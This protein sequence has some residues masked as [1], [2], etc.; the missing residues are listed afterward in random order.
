MPED[1]NEF[2]AELQTALET[3]RR[4]VMNEIPDRVDVVTLGQASPDA[5]LRVEQP[6]GLDRAEAPAISTRPTRLPREF[7]PPIEAPELPPPAIAR[8]EALLARQQETPPTLP[9]TPETPISGPPLRPQPTGPEF[10]L[11]TDVSVPGIGRILEGQGENGDDNARIGPKPEDDPYVQ[12]P[13][14]EA[15]TE[16]A[17]RTWILED[18]RVTEIVPGETKI[19][20]LKCGGELH[21][22]ARYPFACD[23]VIRTTWARSAL[24]PADYSCDNDAQRASDADIP[25]AVSWN[26]AVRDEVGG[27]IEA[28]TPLTDQ[29]AA[30]AAAWLAACECVE[31]EVSRVNGTIQDSDGEDIPAPPPVADLDIA[32]EAPC[33]KVWQEW[34]GRAVFEE[35]DRWCEVVNTV[36]P[37]GGEYEHEIAIMARVEG[38]FEL[39]WRVTCVELVDTPEGQDLIDQGALTPDG[40]PTGHYRPPWMPPVPEPE[41]PPPNCCCVVDSV[42]IKNIRPCRN[43]SFNWGHVFDVW[44]TYHWEERFGDPVQCQLQWFEWSDNFPKWQRDGHGVVNERWNDMAV[45]T[46]NSPVFDEWKDRPVPKECPRPR[47]PGHTVILRD[48]PTLGWESDLASDIDNNKRDLWIKVRVVGCDG[49]K[50]ACLRQ[51]LD[52]RAGEKTGSAFSFECRDSNAQQ[53][54]RRA[55][56]DAEHVTNPP[57]PIEESAYSG[58]V[59]ATRC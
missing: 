7:S 54:D 52:Q 9:R 19:E 48:V 44:I 24:G 43:D 28:G 11:L 2:N 47:G 5:S 42:E 36:G 17:E 40:R 50:A 57:V 34:C 49:A 12:V 33:V 18:G 26:R 4:E 8:L 46:S 59:P 55:D 16:Q 32:C 45:K 51:T 56:P 14:P 41:S 21:V 20:T 39:N 15:I 37:V 6:N 38:W 13:V 53:T 25:E 58:S 23:A 30:A 3:V 22:V 31:K 35:T 27:K 1:D 29:E 10:G